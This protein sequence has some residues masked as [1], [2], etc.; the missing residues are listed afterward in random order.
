MGVNAGQL[1]QGIAIQFVPLQSRVNPSGQDG[2]VHLSWIVTGFPTEKE[3]GGKISSEESYRG[4]EG[5]QSEL[6]LPS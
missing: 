2:V 4:P 6:W 1:M 5:P 3:A